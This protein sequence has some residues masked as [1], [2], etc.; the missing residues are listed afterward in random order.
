[1]AQ[2]QDQYAVL[3]ARL[4]VGGQTRRVPLAR[5]YGRIPLP[6]MH[7]GLF[8]AL[9]ASGEVLSLEGYDIAV[10]DNRWRKVLSTIP[11]AA[12]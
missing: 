5:P 2:D 12:K 7:K 9:A 10:T 3:Q 11:K 4:S 1:M 8:D 6:H